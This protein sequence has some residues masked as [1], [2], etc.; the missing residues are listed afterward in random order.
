MFICALCALALLGGG[1]GYLVARLLVVDRISCT[2]NQVAACPVV[3]TESVKNFVGRSLFL[4]NFR[5]ELWAFRRQDFS[6][7]DVSYQK[8]LSGQLNVDFAFA[9]PLYL[10]V[11]PGDK[12][13]AFD[14][15]GHY[16][17]TADKYH[18]PQ[19]MVEAP[20]ILLA[21]TQY[22][23]D[24]VV[25]QKIYD[26]LYLSREQWS[27]WSAITLVSLRQLEIVTAQAR[28]LLDPFSLDENLQKLVYLET[29]DFWVDHDSKLVIDLRL[30][31]PVVKSV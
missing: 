8:Q 11:A 6:F 29:S 10:L 12:Q 22:Q 7:T 21:L 13:F 31:V 16:T 5:Q 25:H 15:F 19:I 27:E 1:G 17:L 18:L 26:L 23:L 4:T 3:V 20:E 14:E 2:V 28:Y 9:P 30:N 24:P